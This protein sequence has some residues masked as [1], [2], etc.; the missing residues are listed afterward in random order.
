MI[1][2]T[3][4]FTN[5]T[6]LVWLV[7]AAA[8]LWLLPAAAHE[9]HED[10]PELVIEQEDTLNV[11]QLVRS[12]RET[13]NDAYLDE[14]WSFIEPKLSADT[15]DA[16]LLTNAATVAQA[17]HDFD[18]ALALTQQVLQREP[19]NDNAWLLLASI[20]LVQGDSEPAR[21]ACQKIQ[22]AA[23]L[24]TLTCQARVALAEGNANRALAALSVPLD[25]LQEAVQPDFP[26]TNLLAWSLAVAGDLAIACSQPDKAIAYYQR[27]LELIESTQVRSALV[28]VLLE[29]RQPG[30]AES[31]VKNGASAL[32][33]V[34]RGLIAEK[35]LGRETAIRHRIAQVDHEFRHWIAH[36]DWLHAR[37]M[38][39]FY[40]D[41]LP[42]PTLARR[43]AEINLHNQKEPEDFQLAYRTGYKESC[44]GC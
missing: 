13:G 34:I 2:F 3:T 14:A 21:N 44:P 30:L 18:R 24:V 10:H 33:L 17:R 41:V 26:D 36:G 29:T 5:R 35:R 39:R 38:A 43:L 25:M 27:S 23:L 4:V 7:V 11:Q 1:I 42:R 8:T 16:D 32:P 22:H 6:G 31:V 19:M 9:V 40:T 20:H 37:E 12:F 15:A 28:D